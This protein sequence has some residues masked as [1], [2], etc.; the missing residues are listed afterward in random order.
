MDTSVKPQPVCE[1]DGGRKT[2]LTRSAASPSLAGAG[3]ELLLPDPRGGGCN[4]PAVGI[5]DC[6]GE[7]TGQPGQWSDGGRPRPW[8]PA[9]LPKTGQRVGTHPGL[10][11][12]TAHG[13]GPRIRRRLRGRA[14]RFICSAKHRTTKLH[15]VSWPT[16]HPC[17]RHWNETPMPSCSHNRIS[18]SRDILQ[19]PGCFSVIRFPRR[20]RGQLARYLGV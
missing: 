14:P 17:R 3:P 11:A 16:A 20:L 6:E 1:E 9:C 7:L 15:V 4:Y 10:T 8:N 18:L 2:L 5:D 13:T 12:H 19:T